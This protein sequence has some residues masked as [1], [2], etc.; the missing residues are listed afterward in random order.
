MHL[1][2][3]QSGWQTMAVAQLDPVARS[4]LVDE[5]CKDG[6]MF[7]WG[8]VLRLRV[9]RQL[10]SLDPSDSRDL[11]ACVFCNSGRF[12]LRTEGFKPT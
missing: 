5:G 12:R 7:S 3:H 1:L 4:T 9:I 2:F 10:I 8:R 6:T 11:R